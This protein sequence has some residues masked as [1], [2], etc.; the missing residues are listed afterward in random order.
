MSGVRASVVI[1]VK[2]GARHLRELLPSLRAQVVPGGLE[3]VAVDSGSRDDS[4]STLRQHEVRL[5]E[6][7]GAS[8]DH[9]ETRNL[10]AR[11]AAGRVI[12]FLTQDAVPADEHVV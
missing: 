8:F 4:V 2:N 11:E 7:P 10:G 12:V 9:G 6:I 5:F 3:I 1:P